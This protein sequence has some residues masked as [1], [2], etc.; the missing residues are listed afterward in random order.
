MEKRIKCLRCGRPMEQ[1]R[2]EH[3]QMGKTGW[4]LGGLDNLLSGGLD[5]DILAC[6]GCGKLE[7]F[8]G[9][10]SGAKD[11]EEG[12]I[13]QV[14]CHGCGRSYEMDSPKCPFC[15]EKNDKLF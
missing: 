5:V 9:G 15:G 10:W 11:L 2:R 13:A 6:P 12:G 8:R 1:L 7:F 14:K 3:L 4:I